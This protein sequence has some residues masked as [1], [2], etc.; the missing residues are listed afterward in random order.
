MPFVP[1]A[2]FSGVKQ[3]KDKKPIRDGVEELTVADARTGYVHAA[4][5]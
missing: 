1:T 4:S 5:E 3:R 2:A